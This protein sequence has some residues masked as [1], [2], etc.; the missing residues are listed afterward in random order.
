MPLPRYVALGLM[1]TSAVL[2]AQDPR[3]LPRFRGGANLVR[4]DAYVTQNGTA[5]TDLRAEDFEVSEDDVPQ[6][7]ESL[8]LIRPR[9]AGPESARR[10]PAT[11]S[12]SQALASD[13]DAR[14]FVLFMDTWHV[15]TSGSY[16]AQNPIARLLDRVIGQD[17][18]V[19]IMTPEM[20]ARNLTLTRRTSNIESLLRDNWTWGERDRVN[21]SDPREQHIRSC[22][23]DSVTEYAGVA[24]DMIER[25][26]EQKTLDALEDLIQHLEGVREERKF[27][28]LLSEGWLLF[29]RDERLA[30][31]LKTPGGGDGAVP[32]QPETAG[33]DPATGRLRR[34]P[35]RNQGFDSCER[36]RA[37]LAFADHQLEFRQLL[38]R[39][40][41]AN[42]SFYPVDPRGTVAFDE[43]IG[44]DKPPPPAV[45]A[46][47]LAS[48]QSSLK[49]LAEN[50]DGFWVL[51]TD[52]INQALERLVADT[53]SYYLLGY[54]ST[55]L[56]L[57]GKFRRISVRVKRPDVEIRARPGYLAPRESDL[58]SARVDAL[59]NGAPPGHSTTPPSA[60][61][62]RAL[63]G[64]NA[65]LGI[66][67]LRAEATGGPGY[68]WFTAEI[69]PAT[70]KRAEWQEGGHARVTI[71]H[72]RGDTN[73]VV[74]DLDL[75]PGQRTFTLLRPEGARLS[76]GRYVVRVQVSAKNVAVPLQTTVDAYVPEG[77]ALMGKSAVASRR[78]PQTGLAYQR[79]A[80]ARFRRTERVRLEIPRFSNEATIAARLMNREGQVLPLAVP[81][82]ER[83]DETLKVQLIVIDLA[84]APLAQGEYVIEIGATSGTRKERVTYGF[85]LIP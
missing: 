73:P 79:T 11:P 45:D 33:V 52:R 85:R 67:P 19:G 6:R 18:L 20:S 56:R 54:Y 71:E 64:V 39:A 62:A 75:D 58:A 28:I 77:D 34:D 24:R 32:G 16:K 5:L 27:V 22:Y 25:R 26:R 74:A 59:M 46:A 35:N 84:L 1:L 30:R 21:T 15:Q 23:P 17:D 36:E 70:L 53:R 7:V 72:E 63:S 8:E 37:M 13:P 2:A 29:Q 40:N 10:E 66:V 50:T 83:A 78:G 61:I 82:T 4:V 55:N 76:P 47:R 65:R 3:A 44:P 42:V 80:D 51:N 57:D 48:R 12:E 43:P 68:I 49:E 60:T 14:L 81:L 41:R 69:D 9:E 38:Q 31:M